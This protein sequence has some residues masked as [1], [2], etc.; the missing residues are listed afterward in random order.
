MAFVNIELT[1]AERKELAGKHIINPYGSY[2]DITEGISPMY[3]TEDKSSG[4]WLAHCYQHHD[5]DDDLN[6]FLFMFGSFPIPVQARRYINQKQASWEITRI[7][8]PRDILSKKEQITDAIA[9]AFKVYG[10]S[11]SPDGKI[12]EVSVKYDV[13]KV[14]I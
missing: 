4:A 8:L 14:Y 2:R 11:G 1:T 5:T 3:I 10:I 9:E 13:N 12:T 6:E 7:D